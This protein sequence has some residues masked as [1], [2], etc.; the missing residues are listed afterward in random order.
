MVRIPFTDKHRTGHEPVCAALHNSLV[1]FFGNDIVDGRM[2]HGIPQILGNI[3][4]H[5][6]MFP[7]STW[8]LSVSMTTCVNAGVFPQHPNQ[9][10]CVGPGNC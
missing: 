6:R 9:P 3:Q 2:F 4:K 10:L 1:D 8:T 7:V 5:W